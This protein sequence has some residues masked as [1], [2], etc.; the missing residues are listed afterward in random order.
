MADIHVIKN[1]PQPNQELISWANEM[2]EKINSGEI[3][4]MA[5][6][7]LDVSGNPVRGWA[8]SVDPIGMMGSLQLLNVEFN[9]AM[10]KHL[11]SQS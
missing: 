9:I 6:V 2:M 11:N 5:F 10:T 1:N 3:R 7:A 4:C 8:G